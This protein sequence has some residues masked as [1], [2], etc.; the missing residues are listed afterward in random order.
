MSAHELG[1]LLMVGY[2]AVGLFTLYVIGEALLRWILNGGSRTCTACNG[3]GLVQPHG[4]LYW[5]CSAC[6]GRGEVAVPA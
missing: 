6:E 2:I 1:A 3:S 5:R 4:G